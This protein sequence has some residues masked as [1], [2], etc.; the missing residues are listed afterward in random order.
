MKQ[1]R[2][3]Y[4]VYVDTGGTFTDCCLV[5]PDGHVVHGKTSTIPGDLTACFFNS[6]RDA[7]SKT[8]ASEKKIL[9]KCQ[10]IGYG[11]TE[12]TNI[13]VTG[14]GTS[15]LG[16]ITTKG[17]E[18]RTII[19]RL[20]AAGLSYIDGMHLVTADKHPPLIP[21]ERIR[22]VTER[23]DSMGEI[24][25]PLRE[26]DVRQAIQELMEHNVTGIAVCLL[27]SFLNPIHEIR[28]RDIIKEMGGEI[29]ITISSETIPRL[30]EYPRFMSTIL[31]LY[32]GLSLRKLLDQIGSNL[33]QSGYK[34]PLL[35]MQA[36]GGL[37]RSELA[38]PVTT[39]HSGPVGGLT[40]VDYWRNIYGFDSCIGSDVG[41]TSF[42]VSFSSSSAEEYLR[43]PI[44]GRIEISNPMREIRTIGAGGGTIAHFD[45][46]TKRLV[47]G[48]ASAQAV[49]GPVCYGR[50]GTQPTITDADLI[51]GRM[52][53]DFFLGGKMK[54]RK[55][56]ATE[57]MKEKIADPMGMDVVEASEAVCEV[58]DG[59]MESLLRTTIA[60]KGLDP[61]ESPLFAFG[62]MGPTHCAGYTTNL[63]FK[64]IIISPHASIFSALGAAMADVRHI[65]ETSPFVLI[66]DLPYDGITLRFTLDKMKRMNELPSP[67]IERFNSMFDE[68]DRKA[69]EDMSSEGFSPAEVKKRYEIEARYGGQLWEVRFRTSIHRIENMNDFSTLI[70]DFEEEYSKQYSQLAMAP[71]GGIEIIGIAVVSSASPV[72]PVF[73]KSNYVGPDPS[74]G[75]KTKRDV[76]FQKKWMKTA[77]YRLEKL[78]CG[79]VIEGPAILETMDTT[80]VVPD[81]RKVTVDEYSNLIME[82][83]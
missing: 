63:H 83:L 11:T 57:V 23:I 30:R 36:A 10:L 39:L 51:M 1:D 33:H 54:L 28:I 26:D 79:N 2:D 72:K 81:D 50:G 29:P 14:T 73:K 47:V 8:D 62:G 74:K 49:P 48:P 24:I 59:H 70:K 22:G 5:T 52:D 17:H 78:Q 76:F 40:G 58:L 20:R 15:N 44:V 75:F 60:L 53:P 12:G 65:Y 9:E 56:L 35:V 67:M 19:G 68:I 38:R 82:M 61:S 71:R 4:V 13:V 64:K 16:L 18:D 46:V 66:R 27:W 25:I 42:D 7:A 31:D 37:V 3:R 55:D 77:V 21:R 34:Y 6:F 32:I 41:G 45:Q 43:E 69:S 80:V